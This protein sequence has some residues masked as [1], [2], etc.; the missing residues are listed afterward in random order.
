MAPEVHGRFRSL[1]V[2]G[3]HDMTRIH[4]GMIRDKRKIA[5]FSTCFSKGV[6]VNV[7]TLCRDLSVELSKIEE[8]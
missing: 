4:S 5:V 8:E 1:K 2:W 3:T 7:E 6:V